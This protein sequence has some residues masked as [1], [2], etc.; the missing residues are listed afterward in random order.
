MVHRQSE[1]QQRRQAE[2]AGLV[3]QLQRERE[4][5]TNRVA[6]LT[7]E[8][9]VLKRNEVE[10]LKLRSDVTRLRLAA[11]VPSRSEND[12]LGSEMKSILERV[13]KLKQK[14]EETPGAKIPELQFLTDADWME[15]TKGNLDSEADC[16]KAFSYLR[17]S[18]QRRFLETM[19]AALKKYLE[20]NAGQF[21]NEVS[22]LKPY[23][24]TPP[25][26]D[27]LQRYQIV[28]AESVPYE[29]NGADKLITQ[30]SVIDEENDAQFS[31]GRNG[32]GTSAQTGEVAAR[33]AA[34]PSTKSRLR[35][36]LPSA[37]DYAEFD[38]ARK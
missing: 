20:S 19:Q 1:L 24:D 16:R 12:S 6:S 30:K 22:Q 21:P 37:L 13:N 8:I 26:E 4:D 32:L 36:A 25:A 15:A 7:S 18:G 9:A 5:A 10:L 14:L 35:I 28:P 38:P 27:M 31:L 17:D 34:A 23:F 3:Q 2:I 33:V 29:A 11:T